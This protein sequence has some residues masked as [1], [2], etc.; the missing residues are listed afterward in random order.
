MN[1]KIGL[2]FSLTGTTAMTERG[3][4]QAAEFAIHQFNARNKT[5]FLPVIS[6]IASDPA[7]CRKEAEKLASQ[8][9]KIFVGCY[10]SSCRKAILPILEKYDCFLV[11][12]TLY[13]GRE[14]HS[15]VFYTGEVPNQQIHTLLD[16]LFFYYGKNVYCIGNDYVYPRE[17][18]QQVKRYVQD[19]GGEVCGEQYVPFGHQS[20]FHIFQDIKRK[21]PDA[22]LSTLVGESIIPFYQTYC[23]AGLSPDEIPIAS[24][25]TK[26]TEVSRMGKKFAVGHY[27][28]GSY[29]QSL[30]NEANQS[31]VNEF[32]R[33]TGVMSAISSVMFN[34]FLGISLALQAMEKTKS[35][36]FRTI[37]YEMKGNRLNTACGPIVV[38]ENY[39]HLTRNSRIGR[40]QQDGQF[41]IVWDSDADIEPKPFMEKIPE[42]QRTLDVSKKRETQPPVFYQVGDVQTK[43]AAFAKELEVAR[44]ATNSSVNVLI[45]GE[46]GTGKEIIAKTIHSLSNR[47]YKPFISLNAG[48]IPRDIMTSELFGHIE[49][50]FSGSRKGG[51]LG[52]FEAA[53][54][55]TLF[56]DE[57]GEMPPELQ[58]A[59][60]RVIEN[61]TF[62]RIG[63]TEEQKVDVRIIAATNRNLQEEIAYNTFRSDLYYRLNVLSIKIPPLRQRVHDMKNLIYGFLHEFKEKHGLPELLLE[64]EALSTLMSHPWPG[65]VR[66]LRNVLE[67]ASL[68]SGDSGRISINHLPQ[69]LHKS[70]WPEHLV[71][72]K[73]KTLAEMERDMIERA[74]TEAPSVKEAAAI[75][76]VSRSTLYRKMQK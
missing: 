34:T 30:D 75:L 1:T 4:Y 14:C 67:R 15:N 32:H 38:E 25:I 49:G 6:D 76:G 45:T 29:F 52:K 9:V 47:R 26:E 11:Y 10:T 33:F 24:P 55:G 31:F 63:S 37:F 42:K 18:N 51:N 8:G 41:E 39:H 36:D 28:A 46:T 3:Q 50:A 23:E 56:L 57:I 66:E 17:T 22:I 69:D 43:D 70:V 53:D 13:E 74:L 72:E 73:L 27:S 60:L 35:D 48:A 12:P 5:Q 61:Q 62:H 40:A 65:N 59:L 44:L 16:F 7:I 54:G 20:F 21:K 19:K 58:V 68:L 2:L 64:E 71:E